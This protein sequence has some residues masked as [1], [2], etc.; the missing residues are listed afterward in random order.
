MSVLPSH[1][2]SLRR[3]LAV[4]ALFAL[5]AVLSG[6]AEMGDGMT[7]AFADPAKYDLYDCKQLEPERARLARVRPNCRA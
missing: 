4:L 7:S 6:C 5:G 1:R 3:S 2:Q